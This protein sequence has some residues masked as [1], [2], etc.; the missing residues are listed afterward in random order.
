[1]KCPYAT[2]PDN[3]ECKSIEE[4]DE[5]VE[6][7]SVS[8]HYINS[9]FDNASFDSPVKSYLKNYYWVI[10][11]SWTKLTNFYIRKS[12]VQMQDELL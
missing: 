4:I 5:T 6:R 3:I 9:Y 8:L 12:E 11:S 2:N 1:M 10:N 7:L